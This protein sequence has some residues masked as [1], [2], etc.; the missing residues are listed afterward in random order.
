MFLSIQVCKKIA[1]PQTHVYAPVSSKRERGMER[2]LYYKCLHRYL[3]LLQKKMLMMLPIQWMI[4]SCT[5]IKGTLNLPL[6]FKCYTV[7]S[8]S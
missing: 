7:S 2:V 1:D 8:K 3:M 6:V 4:L 5:W